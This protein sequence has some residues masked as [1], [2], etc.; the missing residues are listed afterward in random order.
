MYLDQVI[1][2]QYVCLIKIC[3]YEFN[4]DTICFYDLLERKVKASISNIKILGI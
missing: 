1:L 2:F 3:Y 4:N